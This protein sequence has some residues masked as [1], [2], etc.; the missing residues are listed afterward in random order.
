MKPQYFKYQEKYTYNGEQYEL[1]SAVLSE[2]E[3]EEVERPKHKLLNIHQLVEREDV[4]DLIVNVYV[5]YNHNT[6]SYT[7]LGYEIC[8]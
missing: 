6:F 1:H 8:E 3:E 7:T 2:E 4:G 5:R